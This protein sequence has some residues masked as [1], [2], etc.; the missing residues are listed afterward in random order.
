MQSKLSQMN[1][2]INTFFDKKDNYKYF[3]IC[4]IEMNLMYINILIF[5]I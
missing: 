4:L 1:V 5:I 2:R 3:A